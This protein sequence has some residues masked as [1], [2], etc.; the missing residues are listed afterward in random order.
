MSF[1]ID[2]TGTE[3]CK[4]DVVGLEVGGAHNFRVGGE[5]CQIF[6]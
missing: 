4:M 2:S 5:L 1:Y 6:F 3:H